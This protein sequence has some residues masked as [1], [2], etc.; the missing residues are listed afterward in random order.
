MTMHAVLFALAALFLGLARGR[1]AWV[2]LLFLGAATETL[3]RF[4]P[5]RGPGVSDMLVDWLG[6][7]IGAL[8][9]VLLRRSERVGL[10]L[11]KQG[12]DEDACRL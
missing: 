9:V 1:E 12:I 5:G 8:L 11:E 6:I 4:V 7:A 3:Q 10:F 2:D